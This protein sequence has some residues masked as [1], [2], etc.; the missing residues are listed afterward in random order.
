MGLCGYGCVVKI[1]VWIWPKGHCQQ[2][3]MI[4]CFAGL[5]S[6]DGTKGVVSTGCSRSW[7]LVV[8]NVDPIVCGL[9]VT[10]WE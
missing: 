8:M 5:P 1:F 9:A 7:Q 2:R 6:L 3:C 10:E 4:A